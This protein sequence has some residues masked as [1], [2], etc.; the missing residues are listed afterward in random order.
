MND[1]LIEVWKSCLRSFFRNRHGKRARFKSG[2]NPEKT[3]G[4]FKKYRWMV[5]QYIKKIKE[6]RGLND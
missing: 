4:N 5:Q 6:D 2:K 3:V 1:E